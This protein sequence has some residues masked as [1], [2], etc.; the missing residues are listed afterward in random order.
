[1]PIRPK[2]SQKIPIVTKIIRPRIDI[3]GAWK[4]ETKAISQTMGGR[5]IQGRDTRRLS[6]TFIN[7]ANRYTNNTILNSKASSSSSS[8]VV[9]PRTDIGRPP[10]LPHGRTYHSIS[11]RPRS[12]PWSEQEGRTRFYASMYM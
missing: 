12:Q 9:A 7:R 3:L 5:Q 11:Y 8:S 4:E 10:D 6:K 1:M 2:A